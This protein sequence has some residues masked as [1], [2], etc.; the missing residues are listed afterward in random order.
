MKYLIL[1]QYTKSKKKLWWVSATNYLW[2]K[3][4]KTFLSGTTTEVEII[5]ILEITD[6]QFE[7]YKNL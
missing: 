2:K 1:A 7:N 5:D 3:G 4:S 6:E